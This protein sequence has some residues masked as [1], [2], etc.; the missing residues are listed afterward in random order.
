MYYP[1]SKKI[2]FLKKSPGKWSE[3]LWGIPCGR[4]KINEDIYSTMA[5]ELKEEIGY[6]TQI[7]SLQYL[8]KLFIVQNDGI[9]NIHHV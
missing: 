1:F 9:H 4:I 2:L 3:N 6:E 8:E 7:S 5:R